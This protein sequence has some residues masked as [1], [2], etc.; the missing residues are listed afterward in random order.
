MC[1]LEISSL[2]CLLLLS[3]EDN[4]WEASFKDL[5]LLSAS[6]DNF[7]SY[8]ETF[9][10]NSRCEQLADSKSFNNPLIF[11]AL[12]FVFNMKMK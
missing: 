6:L 5:P 10:F 8:S 3:V 9:D 12:S 2:N 4:N 1:K 11:S 7:I